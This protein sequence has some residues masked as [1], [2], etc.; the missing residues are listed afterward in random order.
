LATLTSEGI[1]VRVFFCLGVGGA[2][3]KN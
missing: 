3:A 2:A 1:W